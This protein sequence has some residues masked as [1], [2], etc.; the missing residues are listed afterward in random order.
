MSKKS[1]AEIAVIIPC[2]KVKDHIEGVIKA[3]PDM[4][5]RIY[6]VD[7]ACP[8]QSGAYI[9]KQIKDAR[10][11]IIA[12]DK[13][14]GVGGAMVTGYKAALE[15]K[16]DIAVKIDG[17]GQM[18]PALLPQFVKPI[19]EGHCDY[20]KG[21]R[22]YNIEDV[23]QMPS[24][25]IFGNAALS[26]M[27]KLSSG[28]WN[29]F[30][31]TN[32]YTAIHTNILRRLPLEKLHKRYFF[33]SDM[34][35]RLNTVRACVYDIPMKAVYGDETSHLKISHIVGTFLYAHACNFF[36]RIFYGYFLRDFSIASIELILGLILMMF[37][38]V[39]GVSNWVNS[40][41]T[42]EPA[43]AGTV[44]LSALP[45]IIGMQLLLSFLHYDIQSVP[46]R[47]V[48]PFSL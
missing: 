15:D 47:P 39:Y 8:D 5:T 11:K 22:F 4:V 21:N 40:G 46:K 36:K 26:F 23:V 20:T 33:E 27:A 29:L 28:Y 35:F 24:V 43:T 30:D 48:H 2:Y 34:L 1:D 32:G 14:Q 37:G 41:V 16:M 13:N 25:R 10:V 12:H 7:D 44:M 45:I 38:V 17:D 18:N 6:C 3:I 19:L 31:P 9:K 42:G